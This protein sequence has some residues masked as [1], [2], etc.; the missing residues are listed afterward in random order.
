MGA[1]MRAAC[2]PLRSIP[3]SSID[4]QLFARLWVLAGFCGVSDKVPLP[5]HHLEAEVVL[6][7][8]DNGMNAVFDTKVLCVAAEPQSTFLRVG[9]SDG[10]HEVAY[11]VVVLG[12]L[13]GGYR[14]LLLRGLYGTRIELAYLFVR[15][16]VGSEPHLWPNPRHLRMLSVSNTD[17]QSTALAST[18]DDTELRQEVARLR[19]EV[20]MLREWKDVPTEPAHQAG[21]GTDGTTAVNAWEL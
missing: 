10:S 1:S 15:I 8:K 7:P 9:V 16:S 4:P 2:P 12:R 19:Q 5:Q 3:T 17:E 14:V 13:R 20:A 18:S 21:R 6:S 11:E